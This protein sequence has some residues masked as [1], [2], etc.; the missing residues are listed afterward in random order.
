MAI[1]DIIYL[2][3]FYLDLVYRSKC[4]PYY[5]WRC[6]SDISYYII[7]ESCFI[8]IETSYN[9]KFITLITRRMSKNT[10]LNCEIVCVICIN[11]VSYILYASHR[12][13]NKSKSINSYILYINSKN[14]DFVSHYSC[15][16]L[17]KSYEI[18]ISFT[19]IVP[20]FY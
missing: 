14:W 16:I 17:V 18:W 20:I 1:I 9:M 4:N 2:V 8:S 3:I 7:N 19:N 5:C 11:Y 13:L 12:I 15:F 10:I 6:K